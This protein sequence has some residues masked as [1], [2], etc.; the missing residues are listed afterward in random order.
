MKSQIKKAYYFLYA[1]FKFLKFLICDLKKI[2]TAKIICFFP[3]YKTGGAEKVHLNIVKAL[4]SENVCVIFT[5]H[6]ATTNFFKEFKE[7]ANCIEINSILNKKNSFVNKWLMKSIYKAINKSNNCKTVFGCNSVYYYS[8]LKEFNTVLKKVDLF[9]NFFEN[10]SRELDIINSVNYI[11]KRIVINE[12]A[13]GEII[14]FYTRNKIDTRYNDRI[15]IIGNG[16]TLPEKI[17]PV[18]N[19]SL[20]KVGFIGRWC[21]EKRPEVYLEIAKEIKK[22]Y[23]SVSFII[24]GTGMRSNLSSII[25]S[26]VDFLGEITNESKLAEL[27]KEL[28]FIV[29]PSIYEGFPMVIME[30]MSYGVIPISTDLEG[31]KEHITSNYNGVLVN[32]SVDESEIIQS[33]CNSIILLIE[34]SNMRNKI[35]K[36]CFTYAHENF[37][38]ENFNVSYQK[39]LNT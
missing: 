14:K 36:D 27:Y 21:F 23:S 10:D 31:I 9:H 22:K 35:A 1:I 24:A 7:N 18:K 17:F 6:S 16:I 11:D 29:L 38:I 5:M 20:I 33:F 34:N 32:N 4:N 15:K 37:G 39:I 2:R 28:H 26:G 19:N 8:I 13:K 12:V 3:F 30:A 25:D